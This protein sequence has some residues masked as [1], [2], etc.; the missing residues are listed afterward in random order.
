M[1]IP[2]RVSFGEI[3]SGTARLIRDHPGPIAAYALGM[4]ALSTALSMAKGGASFSSAGVVVTFVASYFL[5]EIL[6]RREG[7]LGDAGNRR[8]IGAYVGASLLAALGAL[9]G[10]ILLIVPGLILLARWSI[11]PAMIVG[12]QL[13]VI[14]S[15]KASWEATR[16]SQWQIVLAY[17]AL[18]AVVIAIVGVLL[19][20]AMFSFGEGILGEE[21]SPLT[22]S[23]ETNVVNFV[24]E[25]AAEFASACS[26]AMTVAILLALRPSSVSLNAVFE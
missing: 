1:A 17:L 11:A 13:G 22:W 12:E 8:R 3:I 9:A 5:T 15:M 24:G 4:A 25:A 26:T 19:G 10:T 14:E 18:I 6:L 7:Q 23:L 2:N 21:G 16:E 20:G